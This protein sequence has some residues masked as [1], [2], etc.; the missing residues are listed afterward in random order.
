MINGCEDG[1]CQA[2]GNANAASSGLPSPAQRQAET[3]WV[4]EADVTLSFV[5]GTRTLT[6]TPTGSYFEFMEGSLRYRKTTDSIVIPD[7]EARFLIYYDAGVLSYVQDPSR[8]QVS[9]ILLTKPQVADIYWNATAN[10]A[11]YKGVETHTIRVTPGFHE[12]EHFT[13]GAR[14]EYGIGI[15][16]I[17]VDQSGNNNTHAQFGMESG[18]IKD[19]DLKQNPAT[20]A[21]TVG[22]KVYYNLGAE[23]NPNLRSETPAGFSIVTTGTGRAAFNQL[24]GGTWS[25][26]EVTNTKFVLVHVFVNNALDANE[27]TYAVVGQAQY[28]TKS[29]AQAAAPLE[30]ND[31]ILAGLVGPE[32]VA[33]ATMII[34][35]ADSYT[36]DVNARFISTDDSDDFID[37]RITPP[38]CNGG[39]PSPASPNVGFYAERSGNQTLPNLTPTTVIFNSK[40]D[41]DGG[42][43]NAGTGIFTAPT[44]GRYSFSAGLWVTI[45]PGTKIELRIKKNGTVYRQGEADAPVGNCYPTVSANLKL[46]ASDQ[47]LIEAYQASG[48][49]TTI[50]AGKLTSFDCLQAVEV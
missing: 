7:T 3:G 39:I 23:A 35:T 12:Y 26:V 41:D 16:N 4:N 2:I 8:A 33:I 37:H 1:G 47:V 42:D 14:Y 40:Q 34:Q 50:Q 10:E 9:N 22:L 32:Q 38:V 30:I 49:T 43:Y 25:L 48:Q 29:L 45:N 19:E 27:R 46:A 6:L 18:Q 31:I 20:I 36:N 5:N 28:D 17:L 24:S 15:T 44:P 21:S 11:E 13:E